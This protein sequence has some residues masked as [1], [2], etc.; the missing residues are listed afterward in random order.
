MLSMRRRCCWR[1]QQWRY[2][3]LRGR[4]VVDS[5]SPTTS[6]DGEQLVNC[7]KGMK[8]IYGPCRVGHALGLFKVDCRGRGARR[9]ADGQRG[10][11]SAGKAKAP[12]WRHT[13]RQELASLRCSWAVAGRKRAMLDAGAAPRTHYNSRLEACPSAK[14]DVSAGSEQH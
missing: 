13:D 8:N 6:V 4:A 9:S 1:W 3:A 7:N 14:F 12:N 10:T 2:V 11:R 5:Q